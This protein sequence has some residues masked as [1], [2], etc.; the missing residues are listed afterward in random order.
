MLLIL[1]LYCATYIPTYIRALRLPHDPG[2]PGTPPQKKE[3]L[4]SNKSAGAATVLDCTLKIMS[5]S[6]G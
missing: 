2:D 3:I 1:L 4:E 5:V 6:L